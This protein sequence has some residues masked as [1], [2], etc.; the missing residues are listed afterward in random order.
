MRARRLTAED[1]RGLLARLSL[2][3][4]Q[5]AALIGAGRRSVARWCRDGV[6]DPPTVALL[7]I[8]AAHPEL[9]PMLPGAQA[10]E[11]VGHL[12]NQAIK[13]R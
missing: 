3:Q 8:L 5:A 13:E 6:S 2:T 9:V 11:A 12:A 7:R 10:E 1:V 4:G